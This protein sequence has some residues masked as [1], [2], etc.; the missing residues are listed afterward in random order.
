MRLHYKPGACSMASHIILNELGIPFEL[1]K[2]D[3][4]LGTTEAG[5]DFRKISPNGYVPALVTNDGDIITEN[6]AVLQ[7]LADQIPDAGLAP[8]NGTLERTRL[9]EA[10]NFVS[11]ELHK[12]FS[13]F[14]SGA[15]LND[16]ARKKTEAGVGRRVAHIERSLA[17]GRAFLLGDAYTVVD[18]Y[19]F[20]V[21]NWAGFVG[22]SLGAWPKTQ[23]YVAH[24]AARPATV[25]AMVAEGLIEQEQLA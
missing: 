2:T 25:K 5:Q 18:A 20:V 4:E 12:S 16:E 17:D 7:Y 9:Q 15:E 3:T 8:S 23:A 21:L 24:I 11:S 10:L 1:D 22:V 13:P 19:A 14:F 6:P